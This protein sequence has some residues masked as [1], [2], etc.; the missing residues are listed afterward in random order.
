MKKEAQWPPSTLRNG[1]F[2]RRIQSKFQA[3]HPFAAL[4][5][6]IVWPRLWDFKPRYTK[7]IVAVYSITTDTQWRYKSKT[8][9]NL[10]RCGR[11]NML[12]PYLKIWDWD[13]IFG[14][15]VRAISS[16]GVR[17]LCIHLRDSSLRKTKDFFEKLKFSCNTK[18]WSAAHI[19]QESTF[20]YLTN[21]K[22]RLDVSLI[23]FGVFIN[24][25][26]LNWK[27]H[28]QVPS[29]LQNWQNSGFPFL[30]TFSFPQTFFDEA[31]KR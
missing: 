20:G 3:L 23:S 18:V 11:Q 13:L 4:L 12:R 30:S 31:S 8:S 25:A 5:S 14:H 9:E 17:S 29:L 15:A 26:H 6:N 19:E 16:P 27:F 2:E 1:K 22:V 21:V 24:F 10:G 7:Y 28:N